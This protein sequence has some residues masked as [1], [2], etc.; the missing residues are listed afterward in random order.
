MGLRQKADGAVTSG[1]RCARYVCMLQAGRFD[2][3]PV[4]AIPHS[5]RPQG[6]L[7]GRKYRA[8]F[9][10]ALDVFL[11]RDILNSPAKVGLR[12]A[13]PGSY[14]RE[15]EI[16]SYLCPYAV[17]I[18]AIEQTVGSGRRRPS[19]IIYTQTGVEMQ[20]RTAHTPPSET[21]STF[22]VL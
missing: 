11:L 20:L 8:F 15:Y 14:R 12:L 21:D 1:Y 5:L 22:G 7:L 18:Y 17:Y 3:I 10:F 2:G 13:Y 19:P 9:F 16:W 6:I 4:L